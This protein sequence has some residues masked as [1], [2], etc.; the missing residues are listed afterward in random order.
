MPRPPQPN[1]LRVWR[2]LRRQNIAAGAQ[3]LTDASD[4]DLAL[5]SPDAQPIDFTAMEDFRQAVND[6]NIP[7]LVDARDWARLPKSFHA[8]IEKFFVDL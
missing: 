6:S 4:L 3:F 7:I 2:E 8:E 1:S 5:I